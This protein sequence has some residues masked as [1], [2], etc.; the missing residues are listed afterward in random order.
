MAVSWRRAFQH[1][2]PEALLEHLELSLIG[3]IPTRGQ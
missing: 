3:E 1:M 2:P